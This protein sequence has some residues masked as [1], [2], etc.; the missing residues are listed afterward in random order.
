MDMTKKTGKQESFV[1]FLQGEYDPANMYSTAQNTNRPMKTNRSAWACM[2]GLG[3]ARLRHV[4]TQLGRGCT[5]ALGV[6][7]HHAGTS[8]TDTILGSSALPWPISSTDIRL[9]SPANS[10]P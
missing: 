4:E 6:H 8:L 3:I 2:V 9:A 7:L 1:V 5:A 10:L